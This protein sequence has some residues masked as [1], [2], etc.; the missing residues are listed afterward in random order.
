MAIFALSV[1]YMRVK[2]MPVPTS[3]KARQVKSINEGDEMR[4]DDAERRA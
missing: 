4:V 3:R 1:N 2:W